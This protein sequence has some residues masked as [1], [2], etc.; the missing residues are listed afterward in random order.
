MD[1]ADD[2][3]DG[4]YEIDIKEDKKIKEVRTQMFDDTGITLR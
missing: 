3:I 2:D 4:D 1:N